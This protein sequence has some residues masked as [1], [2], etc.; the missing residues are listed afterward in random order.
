MSLDE[1]HLVVGE[2]LFEAGKMTELFE[3]ERNLWIAQ[4]DGFE[5]EIQVSPSRVRA[6]SCE[7]GIFLKEKMCGH[8]AAGL[9]GLRKH[10]SEQKP[11][12]RNTRK[13]PS[14]YH[15]LTTSAVLE[16]VKKEELY[17]FIRKYSKQN[18]AFSL[19]LRTRFAPSVPMVNAKEKYRLLFQDLIRSF[20]KKNDMVSANGAKQ[21]HR[22]SRDMIGQA[23]DLIALEHFA[24]GLAILLTLTELVP[25]VIKKMDVDEAPLVDVV[26]DSF[27]RLSSLIETPIPPDLR[28][29]VWTFCLQETPRVIYR[30]HDLAVHFFPIL[31]FLADDSSKKNTLY[32]LLLEEWGK[33]NILSNAHKLALLTTLL[34]LLGNKGFSSASRKF[35]EEVLQ[36]FDNL[37]FTIS[38]AYSNENFTTAKKLISKGLGKYQKPELQGK[39]EAFHLQVAIAQGDSQTILSLGKKFFLETGDIGYFHQIKAA[40]SNDWQSILAQ[41]IDESKVLPTKQLFHVQ[42]VIY[43]EEKMLNEL[44]ELLLENG[45]LDVL[46][47]YDHN[48]IPNEEEILTTIYRT[49]LNEYLSEHFGVKPTEKIILIF[50][51]LRKLDAQRIVDELAAFVRKK[52][53]RRLELAIEMMAI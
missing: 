39:L 2:K 36:D 18:R 50:S 46:M 33:K 48:F 47:E 27:Q 13:K 44:G 35:H 38:T 45:S 29:N 7:C 4:V 51:H 30:G 6:C 52:Y 3:S 43:A 14:T 9:L 53:P 11:F 41:L 37:I 25:V 31:L 17:A 16:N 5:I 22:I 34:E 21:I 20:R 19:A 40:F 32:D 49:M 1:H 28:E 23:D 10:F 26:Q 12:K 24:E 42:S 8:V 15:K